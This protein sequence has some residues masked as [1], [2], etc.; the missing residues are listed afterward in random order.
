MHQVNSKHLYID[1]RYHEYEI[2]SININVI[3]IHAIHTIHIHIKV[4][5]YCEMTSNQVHQTYRL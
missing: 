2:L 5:K 1:S 3:T 4:S